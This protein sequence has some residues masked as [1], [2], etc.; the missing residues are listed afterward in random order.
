M[1]L[2]YSWSLPKGNA[3]FTN[4]TLSALVFPSNISGGDTS[5]PYVAIQLLN[6]QS[7]GLPIWGPGN[8]GVTVIRRIK[9][10]QQTGYYAQF[11]WSNDGFLWDSGS[12]NTYYGFHPYPDSS[13]NQ[14][15]THSW[16][17]ASD[18]GGDFGTTRGG[19]SKT[20]VKDE[21]FLQALRVVKNGDATKLLT[22]YT[23]LPSTANADVIDASLSAGYGETNPPSPRV[24]IGDS[25]WYA[26]F[27]HERASCYHGQIK[28][29]AK[30]LSEADILSEAANMTSLVTTDGI[31]NIWWGKKGFASVDDLTCDYGTGRSF[32]WAD[33]SNKGTLGSL[34]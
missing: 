6:P 29:I 8:A 34:T 22:F 12:P 28:I 13:T 30:A 20:V 19:S 31:S 18:F 26:G 2:T 27:Q 21:W 3:V 15:T 33:T 7:D 11:W 24:T 9:T 17:I 14:G 25:P 10:V 1:P 23:S 5:A 32:V 4:S 16:E